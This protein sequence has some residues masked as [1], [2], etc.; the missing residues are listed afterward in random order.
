MKYDVLFHIDED[1]M[2]TFETALFQAANFRKEALIKKRKLSPIDIAVNAG[3]P[4]LEK[5]DG[6]RIVL[7][8]NGSAAQLLA[9]S[10]EKCLELAEEARAHGLEFHAGSYAMEQHG[11]RK[12]DLWPFVEVVPSATLDIVMLQHEGFAYI[13][14]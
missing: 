13:K 9:K 8:A 2:G 10:N 3:M 5:E 11:L 7:V 14:P 1:N 4:N 6:F 12:E